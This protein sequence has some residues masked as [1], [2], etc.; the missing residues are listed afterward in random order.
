MNEHTAQGKIKKLRAELE[1]HNHL[2]YVEAS[3]VISDRDYDR[4]LKELAELE[5]QFPHLKTEDSP[6]M[7]VGGEP[8]KSFKTVTHRVPMLSID[9]TYSYDEV[10][11]FD[12][13]V[14]KELGLNAEYYV[15]E[16][17]DGVSIS[18]VYEKGM[19]TR[20]LT[21]GNG[22]QGDDVTAN[23]RTICAV[24]LR[25][26]R[27]ASKNI[28]IPDL[29]EVRGEIYLSKKSFEA[30]NK[31]RVAEDEDLFANPRNAAAG[32]LKLLD[33]KLVAERRLD[34]VVHGLGAHSGAI[35]PTL[36]EYFAFIK[37]CG[38]PVNDKS[39]VCKDIEAVIRYCKA[40]GTKKD[41]LPYEIDG[42][43]IKLNA[44]KQHE[45]MGV[46]SKS[47]RWVIAY[48]Y[49]AEQVTTVLEN[50]VVQVGRRGT[51]TPV[52]E[53][54]PVQLAGTTVSRASLHN[55]DE[56]ERLDARIGDSVVVE[57]SGQIIPKVISVLRERRKAGLKKYTFPKR[58]PSCGEPVFNDE[59]EVAIRCVSLHCAAQLKARVRHFAQRN[60]MDIE[61]LGI[62]LVAQLVDEGLV[63][64]M[65]DLYYLKFDDLVAL[66]RM[67][68]KSAENL[69]AGI[70]GSKRR[71]LA[72][73]IF[74]LGIPNVGQH[75]GEVLAEQ[76]KSIRALEEATVETL[77]DIHEI[78][79]VIAR[80]VV[81][82]FSVKSTQAILRK[83]EDA[84]VAFNVREAVSQKKTFFSGKTFVVTGTLSDFS[85]PEAE[86]M[87]KRLGGRVA[88]SVSAKTDYVV[89]GE[90]PGSKYDKAKK[91]GITIVDNK[92]FTR[93]VKE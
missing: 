46:T 52:A 45:L 83:L 34:I 20:A 44:F 84:G 30:I 69:L 1:R 47:P 81:D 12:R 87:I 91:L 92:E 54:K 73:L 93:R 39:A 13:R 66:E 61:G 22:R 15:E 25:I 43:V 51:L 62:Q 55:K 53:L 14:Q 16:K 24:P 89:V 37:T 58:C 76:F 7:R 38:L 18:L 60:A 86:A 32:T 57:K 49:P 88:K 36:A 11:E 19:L 65:S 3:P 78:G 6:T 27:I 10:R 28:R 72:R 41:A 48:K 31:K 17:I 67:G 82:F 29:L 63:K 21:R 42:M 75:A 35:P 23:V 9:N 80:S 79:P 74:A 90:A 26:P 40:Q 4:M 56:I 64:D 70:E 33:P 71:T 5:Q 68:A 50:I 77:S 59:G 2:Y 85:R 8:L